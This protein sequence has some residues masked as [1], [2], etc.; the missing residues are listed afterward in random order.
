MRRQR[1]AKIVATV[2]P[3]SSAPEKL[4]ELF[5]VGVDVLRPLLQSSRRSQNPGPLQVSRTPGSSMC[6]GPKHQ[7]AAAGAQ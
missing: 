5:L 7:L 2:E 6:I 3:A 1:H 4:R